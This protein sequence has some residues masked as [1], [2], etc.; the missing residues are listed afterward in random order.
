MYL[1]GADKD[2][3]ITRPSDLLAPLRD[4]EMAVADKD[5]Y[6]WGLAMVV[7][8]L[9]G[10]LGAG[11]DALRYGGACRV[12]SYVVAAALLLYSYLQYR[13][14]KRRKTP[15]EIVEGLKRQSTP[16]SQSQA[17]KVMRAGGR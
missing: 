2:L 17:V 12:A 7:T 11:W 9:F 4:F 3:F 15:E 8:I 10:S 13:K 6:R 1:Y 5:G 16:I 14:W